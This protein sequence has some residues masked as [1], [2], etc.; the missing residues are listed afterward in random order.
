MPAEIGG[1][2]LRIRGWQ[3]AVGLHYA[4]WLGYVYQFLFAACLSSVL[5][6]E[7]AWPTGEFINRRKRRYTRKVLSVV[8]SKDECSG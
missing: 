4:G 3:S 7:S 6:T 5:I 1:T 8:Q 2:K